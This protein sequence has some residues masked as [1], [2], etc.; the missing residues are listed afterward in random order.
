MTGVFSH[1]NNNSPCLIVCLCLWVS[2]Q[3][4]LRSDCI[5][6]G[7]LSSIIVLLSAALPLLLLLLFRLAHLSVWELLP[8][9][10]M[11]VLLCKEK[12]SLVEMLLIPVRVCLTGSS[13]AFFSYYK[14]W[15]LQ[16]MSSLAKPHM[17]STNAHI[18]PFPYI[19][20]LSGVVKN[21]RKVW[22]FKYRSIPNLI[23]F[24]S[25]FPKGCLSDSFQRALFQTL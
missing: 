10:G 23:L 2:S 5:T 22:V 12:K 20:S 24:R 6:D 25:V 13:T 4:T 21:S 8:P 11:Q 19:L 15:Q 14:P 3:N 16:L 17:A 7:L 9:T 18:T 1:P